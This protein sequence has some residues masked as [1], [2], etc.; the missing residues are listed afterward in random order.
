MSFVHC[1]VLI[2]VLVSGLSNSGSHSG[3]T[4]RQTNATGQLAQTRVPLELCK[5][6]PVN[7]DATLL[8]GT[9]D[10]YEDRA[11]KSGRKISLNIAVLPARGSTP[12]ADPVFWLDG[13]PGAPATKV[14]GLARNG[15]LSVFRDDHDLVFVDQ[16]G[17]GES[18]GLNCDIGDD[19]GNLEIFFGRLFPPE[20]IRA[21]REKLQNS[22]DVRFYTTSIAMDDLDEVR[23]ALG[24]GK[25]NIVAASYGTIAAQVFMRQHHDSVRSVFL[26]G[27]ATPGVK[28]PLLFARAAQHALDLL[29]VDCAADQV[30]NSAFP[31]LKAESGAV[32][33][34]FDRG[35]VEVKLINPAT[36]S[37]ETVRLSRENY[38][39]RLRFLLYTTT[40]ARF[41][42]YIIHKAYEGDFLPFE[43][44]SV[45]Y[46][47]GG[48]L[49]R[50][51]YLTV[52][53]AEGVPFISKQEIVSEAKGTFVGETR[54]RAHIEAC[55]EW[56]RV[57]VPKSFIDPVTSD[58]PVMMFSGEVDGSSPPWFGK[59]AMKHLPN[60]EQILVRYYGHQL[61]SP[62][63]WEIMRKFVDAASVR[64]ID[65]SC[66]EK[67]R[68]PPFATEIPAALSLQ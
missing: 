51:M 46:N 39:E 5:S 6:L 16:R 23:E 54:V 21:C 57:N 33:S 37:I 31:N 12:R 17:T 20:L 60:G 1:V 32:L 41:I 58:L 2:L 47:P 27:V 36:K 49:A 63:M 61:N 26:V 66:T 56:P 64:G 7:V 59:S 68:R 8:C 18:N 11:A 4:R 29:F 40:F 19:P 52:T 50:G 43:A 14:V 15:F 48:S 24:Y 35:P 13:G 44:I 45:R 10:V 62:C 30:C 67:I 53:C 34:R 65:T 42:P 9:Y 25:I 3:S 38:V 28:Q 55:K 22:A